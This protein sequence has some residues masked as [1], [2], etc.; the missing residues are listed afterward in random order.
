MLVER[1]VG[2]GA[3]VYGTLVLGGLVLGRGY[4]GWRGAASLPHAAVAA[5]RGGDQ[6]ARS[7]SLPAGIPEIPQKAGT[8][9]SR[10]VDIK[11]DTVAQ[12]FQAMNIMARQPLGSQTIK[13][14]RTEIM[15]WHPIPNHMVGRHQD[16]VPH[17]Q[18]CLLRAPAA[19]QSDILRAHLGPSRAARPPA[20]LDQQ[21][22]QPRMA[23]TRLAGLPFPGTLVMAGAHTGPRRHM[24]RR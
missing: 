5:R 6:R 23:L 21:G 13:V 17:R 14:L 24:R 9:L 16:T 18:G 19:E 22:L 10:H 3:A 15:V 12:L 8:S 1:V 2:R 20:T 11:G 4:A 7:A